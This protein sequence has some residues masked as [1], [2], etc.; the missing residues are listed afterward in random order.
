MQGVNSLA[1]KGTQ[2]LIDR[3][4]NLYIKSQI[5]WHRKMISVNETYADA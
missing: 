2:F 3:G 1:I 5:S 4:Q